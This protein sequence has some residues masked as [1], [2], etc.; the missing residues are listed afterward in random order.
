[1]TAGPNAVAAVY[2][3]G[4]GLQLEG[5]NYLVPIDA[6]ITAASD[7][8]LRAVPLSDQMQALAMLHLKASFLILDVGRPTPFLLSGQ[9]PAGGLAWIEPKA[10]MLIAFD[11]A[12]G[13]VSPDAAAGGYGSY[14]RALAEMIREGGLTPAQMFDR[15]RLRVN[16]STK[17]AQVPWDASTIETRFMF[18]GRGPDAPPRADS[19]EHTAWMRSQPMGSLGVNDA[20][21]VA[22][23]RDTFDGYADFVADYWHDPLTKRVRA[24]LAA[25][26]EAITWRR[27]CEANAPEAYWS[28]L[29]RYP[30]GPHVA[31]ARRLLAHLGAALAPPSEFARLDYDV[32]PPLPDE[33]EFV[34]QRVLALADPAFALEPLQ[35]LPIDFLGPPPPDLLV[36]APPA[37]PS[38]A[39]VLPTPMIA[40]LPA[41]V[42]LPADV[43]APPPGTTNGPRLPASVAL[44]A[45]AGVSGSQPP[46]TLQPEEALDATKAPLTPSWL[47]PWPT[48][49]LTPP[50]PTEHRTPASPV[51]APPAVMVN[52]G[53]PTAAPALGAAPP[54]GT[55]QGTPRAAMMSPQTTG[56][57]PPRA[58]RPLAS[59]P[60][61]TGIAARTPRAAMLSPQTSDGIPLPL[62]RPA[63]LPTPPSRAHPRPAVGVTATLSPNEAGGAG[64]S[65]SLQPRRLLPSITSPR[66][67]NVAL[68]PP[69][70]KPPESSCPIVDGQPNCD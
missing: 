45:G 2:F 22:L 9:Q 16:E 61:A 67:P 27:T 41:D 66:L 14:A 28:Y 55:P 7:V 38:G 40:P 64:R 18:L 63:K 17:G 44:S 20:Y 36:L 15:V 69:A 54:T 26:R 56:S 60:P 58:A 3:A 62:P 35:P 57:I 47:S 46:V 23:A 34:E 4:Y 31:D 49:A 59:T 32:P 10:N 37:E 8:P 21:L 5:E 43:A 12:P 53:P 29:E 70:A 11:A 13:T 42:E 24:L 48:A 6:D 65:S 51:M 39:H 25:R 50:W 33:Q 52:Q 19:P 30:R 68:G 1:R